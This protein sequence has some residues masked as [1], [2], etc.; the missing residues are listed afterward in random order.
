MKYIVLGQPTK[1][2]IVHAAEDG[3]EQALQKAK[4]L[5]ISYPGQQFVVY[6]ALRY[7]EATIK[8]EVKDA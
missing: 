7:A 8:V 5:S 6:A 3:L 4:D 2:S 1:S